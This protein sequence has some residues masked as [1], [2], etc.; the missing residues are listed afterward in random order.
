MT[1]MRIRR[2]PLVFVVPT[3]MRGLD[4]KGR[5]RVP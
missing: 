2:Q 4:G 3:G 5:P 1:Q